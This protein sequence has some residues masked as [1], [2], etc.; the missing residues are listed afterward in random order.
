MI[1]LFIICGKFLEQRLTGVQRYAYEIIRELDLI[2]GDINICLAVS[3]STN[4]DIPLTNIRIIKIGRKINFFWEEILLPLYIIKNKAIGIYLCNRSPF[5]R[6]DIVCIHDISP[7]VNKNYFSLLYRTLIT[8]QMNNAI[9]RAQR[10]ITVSCF[11]ESEIIK[12]YG[13]KVN[14]KVVVIANAWQHINHICENKQAL[15]KYHLLSG[16]YYFTLGSI[17][18]SKNID[19]II[20]TAKLNQNEFFLISGLNNKKI[21]DGALTD[22]PPNVRLLGYVSDCDM[23]T[24][25]MNCKAFVF[26][27]LY[28]GFGIPP[29]E[30]YALG[31]EVIVSDIPALRE[32]FNNNAYYIDPHS[33]QELADVYSALGNHKDVLDKY[34]WKRSSLLLYEELVKIKKKTLSNIEVNS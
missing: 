15:K 5:L 23:K 13:V 3:K 6:P 8:M 9:L 2:C 21:A 20:E 26:P 1:R 10:I 34:S 24:I 11:S 17:M 7:I 14:T 33:P 22:L 19:W 25:I 32:I 16:S 4:V 27:S 29:L 18:K 30:A 12:K 31:K 28:E